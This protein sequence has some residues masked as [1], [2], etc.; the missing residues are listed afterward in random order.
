MKFTIEKLIEARDMMQAFGNAD[1]VSAI[2]EI[3]DR[4]FFQL[5]GVEA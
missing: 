3:I 4:L 2:Q 1:E 5:T